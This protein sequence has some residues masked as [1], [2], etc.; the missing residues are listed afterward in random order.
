MIEFYHL[1]F[2]YCNYSAK[3][4]TPPQQRLVVLTIPSLTS[5][6]YLKNHNKLSV[7]TIRYLEAIKEREQTI[8]PLCD[9]PMPWPRHSLQQSSGQQM[10][11]M[12]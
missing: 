5:I 2:Q 8:P 10:Q 6:E 11:A 1:N 9:Q 12:I 7:F 3:F 4:L